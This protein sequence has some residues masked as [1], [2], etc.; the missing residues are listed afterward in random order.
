MVGFDPHA[1]FGGR[2]RQTG[3]PVEQFTHVTFEVRRQVLRDDDRHPDRWIQFT[4]HPLDG[5]QTPCRSPHRH[6]HRRGLRP[7]P[8]RRRFGRPRLDRIA[9]RFRT[10]VQTQITLR[11]RC[12]TRVQ[13]GIM[14]IWQPERVVRFGVGI[15]DSDNRAK[16][17]KTDEDKA[18]YRTAQCKL[19]EM[20]RQLRSPQAG[21][22]SHESLRLIATGDRSKQLDSSTAHVRGFNPRRVAVAAAGSS[23]Q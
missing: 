12:G 3:D 13:R 5:F 14:R 20:P 8:V 11:N 7:G 23:G 21:G 2:H 4:Q 17:F 19:T 1:V 9:I 10:T 15:G 16:G 18:S 6:D 22:E